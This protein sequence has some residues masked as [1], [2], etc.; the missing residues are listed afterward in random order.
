MA[1]SVLASVLVTAVAAA[2]SLG[3]ATPLVPQ[4]PPPVSA[5]RPDPPAIF[6]KVCAEC[7]E[8]G[9]VLEGRRSKSQWS[10]IID[11]MV[12]EGATAS[13]EEFDAILT[14]LVSEYGRVNVNTADAAET[15]QVLH[16][17]PAAAE[18]IVAHRQKH[19]KF[20]DFEALL[21]VPGAPVETLKQRRNAIAF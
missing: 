11:E 2:G 7:H 9:R 10:A 14:F 6:K 5:E 19:G 21:R 18:A 1:L 8:A 3:A 17:D 15:A 12:L 16:L 20:A 4:T 13:D